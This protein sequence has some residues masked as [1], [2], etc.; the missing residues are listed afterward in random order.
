VGHAVNEKVDIVFLNSTG[1]PFEFLQYLTCYT[2]SFANQTIQQDFVASAPAPRPNVGLFVHAVLRFQGESPGDPT[3]DFSA[4]V[5]NMFY[6]APDCNPADTLGYIGCIIAQ[7]LAT[8]IK[9]IQF[10]FNGAIFL[11][12]LI[13]WGGTVIVEF[14]A[15]IV[16]ASAALLTMP[17]E[18]ALAS[19]II[20]LFLLVLWGGLIFAI[21]TLV[22]GN[23]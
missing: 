22:R 12:L 9:G 11:G 19:G 13:V 15:G 5:V 6:T 14:V 3:V 16:L 18:P 23:E 10:L 21:I 17:G 7:G 2:G 20:G 4:V 1:S 8:G